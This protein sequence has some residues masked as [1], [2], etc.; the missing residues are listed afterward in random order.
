MWINIKINYIA[1]YIGIN[2]SYLT[3][4][5]KKNINISP[6]DFLVNYKI[7]KAC[8]LLNSTDLSIKAIAASVGYTD[9]LTFSKIF[10]KQTERTPLEYRA[11]K[12]K[13]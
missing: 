11:A 5:F 13:G 4:I 7:D 10:K 8:E 3:H 6:Q 2:R 12:A 9:P 1:S